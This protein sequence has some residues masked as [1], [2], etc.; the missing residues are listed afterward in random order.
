MF[1]ANRIS[2]LSYI[3]FLS[4]SSRSRIVIDTLA[5]FFD[6]SAYD[7]FSEVIFYV[8]KFDCRSPLLAA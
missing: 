5:A 3:Y 7:C 4:N 2:L 6:L 8:S 1:F